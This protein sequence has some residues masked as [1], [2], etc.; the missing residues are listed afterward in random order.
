[1]ESNV[2]DTSLVGV[3]LLPLILR[4]DNS[5]LLALFSEKKQELIEIESSS[6][7]GDYRECEVC[8]NP[9]RSTAFAHATA[10]HVRYSEVVP[11]GKSVNDVTPSENHSWQLNLIFEVEERNTV[12]LS[13]S[14]TGAVLVTYSVMDS[15]RPEGNMA[16]Y[17]AATGQL[18][19]RC[20]QA[21]WPGMVWTQ[22]D[23]YCVRPVQGCLHVLNGNLLNEDAA[24][25][26]KLDLQLPQDK[27][28]ELSMCP[29]SMPILALFKPF[30]KQTQG[31]LFIYRLP[32]LGDGAMF[33]ATFGR[34][35]SATLLWSGSGNH[36]AVL[37]KSE[38]DASGKSYYGTVLLYL[39]DV[40]GRKI[41]QI[42]F[43]SGESVHDCQWS[44]T[45]DELMVVH[46]KMPVNKTTLYDKAGV[47]LMTF[48]EAPRNVILW[49][50]NGR[51]CTLGGTGNLAGDFVFFDVR[52]PSSGSN[53]RGPAE[54]TSTVAVST[55]EFNHKC[56]VQLWAPDS[57]IFLCAIIFTR[58]RIDNKLVFYKNNGEQLLTQKYPILYGAHWV[59]T[60]QTHL[61][62]MRSA[63]PRKTEAQ[64]KPQPY[65]PPHASAA[66]S[67]L[68][69]RPDSSTPKQ[70]K[71]AGPPGATVVVQKKKRR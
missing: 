69:R 61:Y 52:P 29:S 16:L 8:F 58:L 33:Q 47:A 40:G 7:T 44:P 13:F 27:E 9:A 4:K 60:Q 19:R 38:R 11:V 26:S 21:R 12:A 54:T 10:T 66:A 28:I 34:A 53:G 20:M 50:P 45:V 5:L 18:L 42:K 43:P 59:Q 15:K 67:A 64:A 48:G 51:F 37:V 70:A 6:M 2:S 23:L 55:G 56:S 35:E 57:H 31:T 1:M 71:P 62:P 46:G 36:L 14:A 68:L 41:K 3:P 65:R 24:A 32:N 39:V 25:L 63:S 49:S 22:Q 30:H 17:N